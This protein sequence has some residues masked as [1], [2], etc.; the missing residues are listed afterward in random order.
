MSAVVTFDEGIYCE[1]K[2][3]QWAISPKLDNVIVK[4]F[5]RVVG[6]RMTESGVEDLW[7]ES[8]I[9]GS[10]VA[11]DNQRDALRERILEALERLQWNTFMDWSEKTEK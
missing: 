6:R 9:C 4:N 2:R 5:L 3:I 10:N 8:D 11:T 1:A 7:I